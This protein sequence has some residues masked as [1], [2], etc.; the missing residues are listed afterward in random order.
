MQNK[1]Q[2]YKLLF[3][4]LV[5]SS[6]L[7][8]Y[9]SPAIAQSSSGI[10]YISGFRVLNMEDVKKKNEDNK[11]SREYYLKDD[12]LFKAR[13]YEK[14][15]RGA[16]YAIEELNLN[17]ATPYFYYNASCLQLKR[18]TEALA[19]AEKCI[20]QKDKL[21]WRKKPSEHT[22]YDNDKEVVK[23]VSYAGKYRA[24]MGLKKF[25]EAK[26][27]CRN[28]NITLSYYTRFSDAREFY[29]PICLD[30]ARLE[31]YTGNYKG[32]IETLEYVVENVV[33][34]KYYKNYWEK[35]I[36]EIEQFV[37]SAICE[38][39]YLNNTPD[40]ISRKIKKGAIRDFSEFGSLITMYNEGKYQQ[41]INEFTK[42]DDGRFSILYKYL[43]L[44]YHKL[45]QKQES[46][47]ALKKYRNSQNN[48]IPKI[49]PEIDEI[50][51]VVCK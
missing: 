12:S 38:I 21:G 46:C 40:N 9:L 31:L 1:S 6:V 18:Y 16:D 37:Y 5:I 24:L 36:D 7:F 51:A 30:L 3:R 27:E 13:E 34:S 49:E 42:I 8:L 25:N 10:E 39:N 17:Y 2:N 4:S 20:A 32:G 47:S 43:G 48:S 33:N 14:V 11:I 22:P 41:F 35:M 45:N 15:I 19:I 50:E 44:A 23:A 29:L 26:N 28:A